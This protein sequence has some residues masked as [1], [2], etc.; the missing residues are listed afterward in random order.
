MSGLA[1]TRG[2]YIEEETDGGK[3]VVT[4]KE[5]LELLKIKEE[6]EERAWREEKERNDEYEEYVVGRNKD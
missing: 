6:A 4:T 3:V 1:K 5:Y 2:R